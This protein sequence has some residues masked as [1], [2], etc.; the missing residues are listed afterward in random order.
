MT[1][2]IELGE[3]KQPEPHEKL[4]GHPRSSSSWSVTGLNGVTPEGS[5]AILPGVRGRIAQ[6]LSASCDLVTT[7]WDEHDY[8]WPADTFT[9]K[10]ASLGSSRSRLFTST[11][12]SGPR[13]D[14]P[15][16]IGTDVA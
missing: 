1:I 9:T 4:P 8:V 14:Q 16:P 10:Q 6:P 2:A 11:G 3:I 12:A 7:F 13:R 15:E 5:C